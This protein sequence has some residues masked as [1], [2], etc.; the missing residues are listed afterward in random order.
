LS[1]IADGGIILSKVVHDKDALPRQVLLY[2]DYVRA[3]FLGT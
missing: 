2:R 1:V 3:T